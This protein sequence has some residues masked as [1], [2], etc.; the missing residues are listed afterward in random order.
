MR[1]LVTGGAGFI[2]GHI[3]R[4][5]L[6]EGH[7]VAILDNLRRAKRERVTPGATFY[8]VDV[9]D[10]ATVRHAVADYRPQAISHQAAQ[11]SVPA[12]I[13]DPALDCR[14]NVEGTVNL[15]QAA[16]AQGVE[17]FVFASTGGAIYGEVAEGSLATTEWAPKPGSP[18]AIS[19]F[20]AEAY[21][22]YA[23]KQHGL[24]T[25]IL[26]YANVYGPGQ[27]SEGEAGVVAIFLERIARGEAVT[28]FAR[29]TPG[30]GGCIR[31]YVYVSDVA[32]ANLLAMTAAA[33]PP[34]ANVS[35]G[36]ATN[37]T[38]LADGLARALGKEVS[39][40]DAGPRRGDLECSVLE[41]TL[42]A[43]GQA[44]SL[45]QGLA[46]VAEGTRT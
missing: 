44:V 8:E 15:L 19:K 28:V 39:I 45:D 21:V 3:A 46:R 10:E 43:W 41:P 25:S 7:E 11:V 27:S 30:D 33:P 16:V 40:N 14:I 6:A 5:A 37:T 17:R 2:G 35:T 29:T 20:A 34:L 1:I 26:R 18:Y 38:T 42:P 24:K 22:S 13:D 31:D 12:S 9:V 23:A 32:D 4:Q 36:V